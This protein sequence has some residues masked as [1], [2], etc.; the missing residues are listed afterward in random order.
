MAHFLD[1]FGSL[2]FQPPQELEDGVL[3]EIIKKLKQTEYAKIS[4]F[5]PTLL[6]ISVPTFA[7]LL[8]QPLME[9][10][11]RNNYHNKYLPYPNLFVLGIIRFSPLGRI[12]TDFLVQYPA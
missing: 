4:C 1:F 12:S 2:G 5:S 6:L 11:K 8:Q 9:I 3:K 7:I 10:A